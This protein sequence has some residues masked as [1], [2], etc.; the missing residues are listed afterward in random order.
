MDKCPLTH[1]IFSLWTDIIFFRDNEPW[2]LNGHKPLKLTI[3]YFGKT[4]D[5]GFS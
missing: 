1:H 4:A 3:L 5:Y 2:L